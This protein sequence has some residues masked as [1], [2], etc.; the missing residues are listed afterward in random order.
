VAAARAS[1]ADPVFGDAYR[2]E[3][4]PRARQRDGKFSRRPKMT[5]RLREHAFGSLLPYA[6]DVLLV[7]DPVRALAAK[8]PYRQCCNFPILT[9]ATRESMGDNLRSN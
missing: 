1:E 6:S 7:L 9:I 4:Y 5:R 2:V 8:E 3:F